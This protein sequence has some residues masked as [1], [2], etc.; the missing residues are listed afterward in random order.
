MHKLLL[1]D[2]EIDTLFL[3][4]RFF[5]AKGFMV[6]TAESGEKAIQKVKDI[7]PHIVLMDIIMPGMGGL[8]ALKVIKEI[9]PTIGVIMATAISDEGI[10]KKAVEMGA[11]DYVTKPFDLDYMETTALIMLYKMIG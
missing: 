7:R 11:Y 6:D 4:K 2:D 5:Q 9:N 10:A 8:E 1:V 3:L